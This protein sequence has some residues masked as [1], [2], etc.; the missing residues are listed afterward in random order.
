MAAEPP[1]EEAPAGGFLDA[2]LVELQSLDSTMA[3]DIKYATPNNFMG[4]RFYESAHAF[5]RRPAAAALNRVHQSLAAHG[6]GLL[7]FDAYRPWHVTKMFWDATPSHLRDFVADPARGSRH[8]RGAA[9]DLTLYR[10]DSGEPV[11]MVSEYDDFSERAHIEYDGGSPNQRLMR[12]LLRTSM[13]AEGFTVYRLEW[14][15]YD[16]D[17]WE[18]FRIL[19]DAF[20]ELADR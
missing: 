20:E 7:V 11:E 9:V 3:Y 10:L 1:V 19:N 2:E 15:H 6:L 17:G 4:A 12:D 16:F 8:N 14:W 5:L 13:E 18:R